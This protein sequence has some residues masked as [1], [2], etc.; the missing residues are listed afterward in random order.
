MMR[1]NI[2]NAMAADIV[3]AKFLRT[4]VIGV[5]T[6]MVAKVMLWSNIDELSQ[7]EYSVSARGVINCTGAWTDKVRQ[8][9]NLKAVSFVHLRASIL[10]FER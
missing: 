2:E 1:V 4:K 7:R 3:G 10:S 5:T 8:A 6:C 9:A